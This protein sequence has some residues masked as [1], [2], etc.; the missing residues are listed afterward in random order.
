M[1][2]KSATSSKKT[3]C[4]AVILPASLDTACAGH[5]HSLLLQAI[6]SPETQNLLVDAARLKHIDSA[7]IGVLVFIHSEAKSLS[8]AVIFLN[9]PGEISSILAETKIGSLLNKRSL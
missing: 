1:E 6:R 3:G 9:M 4:S 2:T 7:G 5:W 8:K